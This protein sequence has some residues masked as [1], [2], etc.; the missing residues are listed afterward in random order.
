MAFSRPD[1][2][3]ESELAPEARIELLLDGRREVTGIAVDDP[4]TLIR[5]DVI[6]AETR[7]DGL[8][9]AVSVPD[10]PV[11]QEIG[12]SYQHGRLL[13]PLP[14]P[15]ITLSA[16]VDEEIGLSRPTF[17]RTKVS[18]FVALDHDQFVSV[19]CQRPLVG[20]PDLAPYKAASD[21]LHSRY[22]SSPRPVTSQRTVHLFMRFAHEVA[23]RCEEGPGA[24]EAYQGDRYRGITAPLR[25]RPGRESLE[26]ITRNVFLA[27]S[28]PV[29]LGVARTDKT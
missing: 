4:K 18:D 16:V 13:E 24:V 6:F 25:S 1:H 28:E 5:E 10:T 9:I 3:T 21:L 11:L 20:L 12:L 23:Q 19:L 2:A 26:R 29:R 27:E 17:E 8:F 14:R 22:A 15:T 7:E